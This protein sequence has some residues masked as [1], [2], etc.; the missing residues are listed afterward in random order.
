MMHYFVNTNFLRE[1]QRPGP[2][3]YTVGKYVLEKEHFT[4]KMSKLTC[5]Y[6]TARLLN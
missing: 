6:D 5:T 4:C 3:A 1:Y 2:V